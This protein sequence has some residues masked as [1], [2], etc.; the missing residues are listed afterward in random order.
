MLI[1]GNRRSNGLGEV[2]ANKWQSLESQSRKSSKRLSIPVRVCIYARTD[3]CVYVYKSRTRAG[4]RA[5]AKGA[6]VRPPPWWTPLPVR[7]VPCSK[8]RFGLTLD[9]SEAGHAR[10]TCL[11]RYLR[12]N[13][14]WGA[15]TS[16]FVSQSRCVRKW[17]LPNI[18]FIFGGTVVY[19]Y[20]EL[21][22]CIGSHRSDI[23]LV[24]LYRSVVVN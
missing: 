12:V 8:Q 23:N 22:Y 24:Y 18:R 13:F 15:K 10:A 9:I 7:T 17:D 11:L 4:T 20:K 6:L 16:H 3:M 21:R 1:C 5:I 2:G 19:V 14:N